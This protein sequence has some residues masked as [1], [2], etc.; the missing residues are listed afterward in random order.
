MNDFFTASTATFFYFLVAGSAIVYLIL[1]FDK[2][3]RKKLNKVLAQAQ[4]VQPLYMKKAAEYKLQT[5]KMASN[6]KK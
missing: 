1:K 5:L 3:N 4:D 2:Q 6:N